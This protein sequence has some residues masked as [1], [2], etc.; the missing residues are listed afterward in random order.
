MSEPT[1]PGL[2]VERRDAATWLVL[3]RPQRRNALTVEL[4]GTLTDAIA[5]TDPEGTAAIVITG[6]PPAFCAGG[7][8]VD[9]GAVADQGA[10]AVSDAVY[11]RFHRLLAAIAA[12]P[13]PVVAA[14]NG[15]ALGAGLDLALACDL[16]YAAADATFASSWITVGLVPGMGGAHLLTQAVGATRAAE[17][18]LLGRPIDA[19]VALQWGLVNGIAEPDRLAATVDAVV[20]VLAA[21]PPAGLRRSKAALRRARD[22]G[23]ADEL[24]TLGAVQGT[25]LTGS[26]FR[27]ATERFRKP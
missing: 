16:R 24:A 14:V 22:H 21:L 18:V 27:A 1:Q 15:V 7:D 2:R 6:E 5:A 4:V 25:L 17:L 11:G 19:D 26:E 3:D 12:A 23:M 20:A 9:L 13:V 10:L 8:L